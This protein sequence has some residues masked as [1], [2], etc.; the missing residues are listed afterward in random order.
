MST[1][2]GTQPGWKPQG[3]DSEANAGLGSPPVK[4]EPT[5]GQPLKGQSATGQPATGEPGPALPQQS[6]MDQG[7]LDQ[8]QLDQGRWRV[9]RS[10]GLVSGFMLFLL[11]I[12]G[13]LIPF[14]GPTFNYAFTPDQ[15]W[16]WTA[17]RFWLQVLP[18]AVVS[19]CGLVLMFTASRALA[20]MAGWIAAL[21][22][23][24]FVVGPTISVY[25]A[26]SVSSSGGPGVAVGSQTA[27]VLEQIGFFSGLGGLIVFF[28]AL[29]LGR[30]TVHSVRDVRAAEQRQAR[31]ESEPPAAPPYP[32]TSPD[33]SRAD[34][35]A[36][37]PS[38][39]NAAGRDAVTKPTP[40]D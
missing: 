34:Y 28:A 39:T 37:V 1:L 27:R 11:G 12:W 6:P 13:A 21:G 38:T 33:S 35:P 14:I 31:Y 10:R 20:V 17:G 3:H 23:G 25:W 26:D 18:G 15:S 16:T 29:V 5:A 4:G 32:D 8:G 40:Q 24:W 30:L 9:A 19:V 22:G 7:L 2:D 36:A